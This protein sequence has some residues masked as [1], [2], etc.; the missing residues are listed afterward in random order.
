[1][2]DLAFRNITRQR[3]RTF[4][5]I[6]GIVIGIAAIVALGSIAAGIDDTVQKSLELVAGRIIVVESDENTEGLGALLLGMNSELTDEHVNSISIVAGVKDTVPMVM[7]FKSF[8]GF[9]SSSEQIVGME[10]DKTEYFK[11]EKIGIYEGRDMEEGDS[12]VALIGKTIAEVYN[13]EPGDYYE[14]GDTDFEIIGIIE[15]TG[16]TDIDMGVIVPIED[17]QE[18]LDIDTYQMIYVIPDDITATELVAE[19]IEDEVD[20]VATITGTEITR[21]AS[22]MVGAISFFTIGIGA[23]AAFVG[24]LGVMNTMIMAVIERRREIGVMKAIGATNNKVLIQFLTESAMISMIGGGVGCALGVFASL[25][26]TTVAMGMITTVATWPLLFFA[27]IFALS[28]GIVGGIYPAW[29]A[30][31]LDPVDALR[32]E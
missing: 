5:T 18:A 28:L 9:F 4:L 21:Q 12:G 30:A 23:V 8:E 13:L 32:Y 11:G 20:D 15:K 7:H 17:L 1:M 27:F 22:E 31:K 24:G 16:S 3:S 26:I 6:L 29:K 10:P 25:G 2:I 19:D 14:V